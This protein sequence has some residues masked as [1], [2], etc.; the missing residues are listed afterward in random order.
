MKNNQLLEKVAEIYDWLELQKNN[1]PDLAGQCKACGKCCNFAEFDHRLFVTTPELI[2][3]TENLGGKNLKP[4]TSGRCPYNIKGKCAVY[5]NR[6]AGCR[7]F[8]CQGDRDFQSSLSEQVLKRF[9]LICEDF[10]IG[11]QYMDLATALNKNV[12]F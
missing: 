11:Y 12:I 9:K 7:I 4:M 10:A 1:H 3:L 2:Y 8:C 6:F 5:E